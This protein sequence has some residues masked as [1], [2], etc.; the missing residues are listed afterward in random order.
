MNCEKVKD[1]SIITS[2]VGLSYKSSSTL[3][4]KDQYIT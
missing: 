4:Q 3:S 1:L 2:N